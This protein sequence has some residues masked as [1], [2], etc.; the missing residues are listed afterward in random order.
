[1]G[2]NLADHPAVELPIPCVPAEPGAPILHSIA[3]WHSSQADPRGAP[4]LL[5][6]VG[7]PQ[8][9]SDETALECLLMRPAARGS[10]RLRSAD[11]AAAPVITLPPL[12]HQADVER[13]AEAYGRAIEIAALPALLDVAATAG[14]SLQPSPLPGDRTAWINEAGYH[15]PHVVGTCAMGRTPSDGAVVD[16]DARVHGVDGL[17]VVDASILPDPP[18]GFPNLVTMM[19]ADRVVSRAVAARSI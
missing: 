17:R 15:V 2:E 9:D 16:A 18:S 13:L 8:G 5:Y 11:P 12:D 3:T 4:D 14:R 7:D 1:V 10:V 6:W 19:V